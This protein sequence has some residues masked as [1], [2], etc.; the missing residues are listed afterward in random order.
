MNTMD[1]LFKETPNG[2][3]YAALLSI[4]AGT[5]TYFGL[6]LFRALQVLGHPMFEAAIGATKTQIVGRYVIPLP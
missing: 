5:I 1:L 3:F 6:R 4:S 2:R